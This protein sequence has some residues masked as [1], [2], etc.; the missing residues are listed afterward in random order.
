M[1]LPIS[2]EFVMS[3]ECR[4]FL[5]TNA[6]I[7]L[8]NG[9]TH[10]R[11][12]LESASYVGTS[13]ICQVEYLTGIAND[14]VARASFLSMLDVLDVVDLRHGDCGLTDEIVRI[15]ATN[16]HVKMPDAIVMAS[17][18]M[19]EA[20]LVTNDRQLHGVGFCDVTGF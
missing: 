12:M 14:V 5:D 13:V 1:V 8:G 11:M 2:G 16:K 4:Y 15:R 17:A 9:D 10:L 19:R 18:K 7:A 3:G 6:L 20:T